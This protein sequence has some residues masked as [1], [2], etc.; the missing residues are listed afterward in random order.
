MLFI[1]SQFLAEKPSDIGCLQDTPSNR[2]QIHPYKNSINLISKLNTLP[3]LPMKRDVIKNVL[4]L[5]EQMLTGYTR[6]YDE[7]QNGLT[8]Q[9][10]E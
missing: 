3:I 9:R 2:R 10:W 6:L 7:L 8:Q 4:T 1:S 5:I